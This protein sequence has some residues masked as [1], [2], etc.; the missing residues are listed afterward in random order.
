MVALL[1][2]NSLVESRSILCVDDEPHILDALAVTLGRHYHI[3]TASSG[4]AAL[5]ILRESP[6]IPV[7]ISDMRMPSMNGAQFLAASRKIAPNARRIL[8]TGYADTASAIL[9]VNEGGIF[10]YLTKPCPFATLVE[11]VEAALADFDEDARERSAIRRTVTHDLRSH[12]SLTGL[13]SRETLLERLDACRREHEPGDWQA[14]VVLAIEISD[15]DE[16][17]GYDSKMADRLICLLSSTLQRAIPR[18]QCLARYREATFVALIVP[19]EQS[20]ESLKSFAAGVVAALETPVE[21]DGAMVQMR[22]NVGIA[23]I[24]TASDP[25]VALRYAELAAREAKR[26]GNDAVHFFS[27]DSMLKNERRRETI[28]ALRVA[29]A[30]QS[31]SLCYQPIVDFEQHRVYSVEALARWEHPQLGAVSPATFIP[32]AEETGLMV[33]LGSWVMQ[34]ACGEFRNLDAPKFQRVSVNVSVAQI[35]DSRFMYCLYQALETSRIEPAALELELTETV[36]AEDLDRVCKLLSEVRLLG[37]SV[38]IDDFGAGYSSLSYL[39]RLPVDVLKIDRSFVEDFDRGG[40]T[41]IAA[42]LSVA[43]KLKLE[44]IVEGVETVSQLERLRA[45]GACKF[46]GY[47]FARPMPAASLPSWHEDFDSRRVGAPSHALR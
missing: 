16:S 41:I 35:L 15:F 32:L 42:A 40:E 27:Q 38:A 21:L 5:A 8:L 25:R 9:A 34:R 14:E 1:R 39:A 45:L 30:Q 17:G 33:P 31:L 12:D 13:A 36:F 43:R 2:S 11:A 4:G 29:V 28:Q 20:D 19:G 47:L 18:A 44:V 46:Q 22:A 6:D 24:P 37:V 23:R 3:R 26:H 7:I 10:R